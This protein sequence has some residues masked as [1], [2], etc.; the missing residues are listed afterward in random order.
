MVKYPENS[1][2][3]RHMVVEQRILSIPDGE[4][5]DRIRN[6]IRQM[7]RSGWKTEPAFAAVLGLEGDPYA[8]LLEL[9]GWDEERLA[10]LV[11]AAAD[12]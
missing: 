4:N 11:L 5:A 9:Y 7:K 1:N 10:R 8:L 6:R 12:G 2:G 3:F